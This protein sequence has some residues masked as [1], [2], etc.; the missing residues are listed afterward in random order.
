MAHENHLDFII[1]A[2]VTKQ[3]SLAFV[4]WIEDWAWAQ[5]FSARTCVS[6]RIKAYVMDALLLVVK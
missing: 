2:S 3:E 5:S 6:I 1:E 4:T